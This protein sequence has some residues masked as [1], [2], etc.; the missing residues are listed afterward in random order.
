MRKL[1]LTVFLTLMSCVAVPVKA[2][3]TQIDYALI[4]AIGVQTATLKDQY[5]KR[6]K[7]HTTIEIA[8]A[9]IATAMENVHQVEEKVLEYMANAS[10]VMQNL[11]QLKKITE[12]TVVKIP[13]NLVKLGKGIP[14]NIKGTVIS[15]LVSSTVTETT[16]DIVSLAEIV[17]RLVT[18]HYSFKDSKDSKNINLLSAAER[19]NIL[20]DVLYK[21][22]DINFRI[23]MM[24]FYIQTFDWRDLWQGLDRE[25]WCNAMT[26][27]HIATKLIR[28]W[29]RPPQNR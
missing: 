28:Q 20:Q 15:T 2:A 11:N 25:S 1:V 27:K 29:N 26:G 3:V 9:A 7:H 13:D 14:S 18:S 5:E 23:Y 8:Q 10:G 22:E 19:Y 4:A 16:M 24:R 12:L 17:S 6:S 21:L